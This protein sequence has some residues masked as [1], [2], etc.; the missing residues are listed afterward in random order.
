M[1]TNTFGPLLREAR[2]RGLL[3]LEN[4][5]E[6]SGVSVRAISDME[7]GKSLPRQ[8]TLGELMDAL[9]VDEDQRRRLVTAAR[10]D[11]RPVPR[12][13]PPDLSVFRGREGVLAQLRAIEDQG[14]GVGGLQR[15]HRALAGGDRRH[16][17]GP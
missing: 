17:H 12:Q 10:P 1:G 3:T 2:Q 8:A 5:A 16:P 7:R 11:T 9:E 4:L 14:A 15:V 6:A 13:L